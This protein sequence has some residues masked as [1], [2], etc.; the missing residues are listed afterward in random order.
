MTGVRGVLAGRLFRAAALTPVD[1]SADMI[2]LLTE[3][4][5]VS[6]SGL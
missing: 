1:E 2:C 5:L 4:S 3:K 6:V